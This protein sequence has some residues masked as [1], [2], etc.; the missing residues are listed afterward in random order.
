MVSLLQSVHNRM[1]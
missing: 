1:I